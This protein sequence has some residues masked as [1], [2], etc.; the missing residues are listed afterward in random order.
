MYYPKLSLHHVVNPDEKLF[1]VNTAHVFSWCIFLQSIVNLEI[2]DC[3][4]ILSLLLHSNYV[5]LPDRH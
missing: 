1:M 4:A 3:N 5:F 2:P